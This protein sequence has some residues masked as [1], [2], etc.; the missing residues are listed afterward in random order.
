MSALLTSKTGHAVLGFVSSLCM[1][2]EIIA[3]L[4]FARACLVGIRRTKSSC[5]V[6]PKSLH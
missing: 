6:T 4:D 2:V 1:R 3:V 5:P